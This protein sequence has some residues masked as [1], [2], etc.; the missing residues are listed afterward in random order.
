MTAGPGRS[1][2]AFPGRFPLIPARVPAPLPQ[3]VAGLPPKPGADLAEAESAAVAEQLMEEGASTWVNGRAGSATSTHSAAEEPPSRGASYSRPRGSHSSCTKMPQSCPA[4][5]GGHPG[6][7]SATGTCRPHHPLCWSWRTGT[8][9]QTSG[10]P[11]V[12]GSN[13]RLTKG[14]GSGTQKPL[15]GKGVGL[16]AVPGPVPPHP[17]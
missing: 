11:T 9:P 8:P 6:L 16:P 7:S 14:R 2:P 13:I 15:G 3:P 4:G 10:L 1:S 5:C 12:S 17:T